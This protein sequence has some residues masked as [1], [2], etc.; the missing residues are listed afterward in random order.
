MFKQTNVKYSIHLGSLQYSSPTDDHLAY[1]ILVVWPSIFVYFTIKI[2]LIWTITFFDQPIS[3]LFFLSLARRHLYK[4]SIHIGY[5][6][7]ICFFF[8][9]TLAYVSFVALYHSR[10]S[11]TL[12]WS[13][14]CSFNWLNAY[15]TK[16]DEWRR[17]R[18]C[19][20]CWT[21]ARTHIYTRTPFIVMC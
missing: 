15:Q 9:G 8:S 12:L 10:L 21:Y 7:F 13:W 2:I 17:K 11:F 20:T 4:K 6:L 14:M 16:F 18:F 5:I 1:E 3:C 19:L